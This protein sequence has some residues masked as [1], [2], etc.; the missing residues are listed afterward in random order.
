MTELSCWRIAFTTWQAFLL[1]M[2]KPSFC[3]FDWLGANIEN[4]HTQ[5]EPLPQ[6]RSFTFFWFFLICCCLLA[7][8]RSS[9]FCGCGHNPMKLLRK[10]EHCGLWT[11]QLD[12]SNL[13]PTMDQNYPPHIGGVWITRPG[14]FQTETM[15]CA[16]YTQK[17]RR[18]PRHVLLL[19]F[20]SFWFAAVCLL[21]CGLFF[22]EK[23]PPWWRINWPP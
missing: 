8:L 17:G 18:Y 22:F 1:K 14:R 3:F 20:G 15:Y 9:Q 6:T 13:G 12:Y 10:S 16:T 7:L 21:F 11:I 23:K 5:G 4:K 2:V 19:S